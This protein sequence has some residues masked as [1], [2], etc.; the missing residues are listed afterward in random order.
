VPEK[1][2]LCISVTKYYPNSNTSKTQI[3]SDNKNKAGIYMWTNSKNGKCYIG[4]A[5]DLSNRLKFY[6][7]KLSMENYLKNSK[8]SIYNAILK[9]DHSNFSLTILEYCEPEKCLE[10]ERY[11][12]QTLNPE[13]NIA[14]EPGAPMSGRKHSDETKQIMSDTAK[15]IYNSGH[16]NKGQQRLEGAGKSLSSNRSYW[17]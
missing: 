7:S 15:K 13:Y 6:Y 4:S 3:L 11:Y 16:F 9:Y 1:V 8:S 5:V 12:Q 10:R 2:H 14:K 17:Y